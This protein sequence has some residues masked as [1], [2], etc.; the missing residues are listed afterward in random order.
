MLLT[1]HNIKKISF[2]FRFRYQD[3]RTGVDVTDSN[4]LS[5]TLMSSHRLSWILSILMHCHRLLWTV[6]V[7]HKLSPTIINSHRLSWTLT[8]SNETVI[9]SDELFSIFMN[10]HRLS[11]TIIDSRE[12]SPILTTSCRLP[13]TLTSSHELS[14]ALMNSYRLSRSQINGFLSSLLSCELIYGAP[15]GTRKLKSFEWL[16]C[17]NNKVLNVAIAQTIKF[18]MSRLHKQ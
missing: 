9:D 11:R 12:L 1:E 2:K 8:G 7:S 3:C 10:F 4:E 18:W 15:E 16:D 17:T 5:P 13:R 14:S 6:T